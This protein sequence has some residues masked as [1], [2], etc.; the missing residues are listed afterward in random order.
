ML[1]NSGINQ[2]IIKIRGTVSTDDKCG[3]LIFAFTASWKRKINIRIRLLVDRHIQIRE[4]VILRQGHFKTVG[5]IIPSICHPFV[6]SFEINYI[7]HPI[8]LSSDMY[9][10][11]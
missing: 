10:E 8:V 5:G 2:I 4:H 9:P 6:L 7:C 3:T 11:Q 1:S